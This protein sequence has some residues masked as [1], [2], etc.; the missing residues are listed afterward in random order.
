MPNKVIRKKRPNPEESED[1][2]IKKAI[3][4]MDRTFEAKCDTHTNKYN[5]FGNYICCSELRDVTSPELQRLVK[6][7]ISTC[8]AQSGIATTLHYSSN[9][10]T[11]QPSPQMPPFYGGMS[12]SHA[13]S[14]YPRSVT[15]QSVLDSVL[16]D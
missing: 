11:N 15:P 8:N 4:C 14:D 1:V 16:Q 2:L 12:L 5:T 6:E 9:H 7:Q 3:K 13:R 10:Y